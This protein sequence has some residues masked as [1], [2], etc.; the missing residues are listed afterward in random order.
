MTARASCK[1]SHSLDYFQSFPARPEISAEIDR[2]TVNLATCG[3]GALSLACP[4]CSGAFGVPGKPWTAGN[5]AG[6]AVNA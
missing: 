5:A 4:C 3:N 2:A 6:T 1:F